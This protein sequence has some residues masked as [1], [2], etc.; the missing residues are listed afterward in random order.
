MHRLVAQLKRHEGAVKDARGNHLPYKCPE[1]KLTIGYGR[2]IEERGITEDEAE[3]LLSNDILIAKRELVDTF[4]WF[5][6]LDDVRQAVLL[7]MHFNLGIR[8]LRGFKRMLSAIE[9]GNWEAAE[10]HG[11]DSIWARQVGARA[12]ELMRQ[13]K[14]GEWQ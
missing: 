5:S 9:V 12:T 3:L 7:N 2:N 14:L 10:H 1:D 11:L 4:P 13:L 8:S 6:L